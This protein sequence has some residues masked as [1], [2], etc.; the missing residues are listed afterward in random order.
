MSRRTL[1][2]RSRNS[3]SLCGAGAAAGAGMTGREDP[4]PRPAGGLCTKWCTGCTGFVKITH[5][6]TP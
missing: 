4:A 3:D 1:Q 5:A 2:Y 6:A